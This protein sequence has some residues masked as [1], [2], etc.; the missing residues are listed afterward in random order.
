MA[1]DVGIYRP[2]YPRLFPENARVITHL[3]KITVIPANSEE[4]TAS[5]DVQMTLPIASWEQISVNNGTEV[6]KC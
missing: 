6:L 2:I 3:R 5:I 1:R 4:M